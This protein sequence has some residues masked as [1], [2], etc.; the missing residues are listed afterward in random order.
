MSPESVGIVD[1][2]VLAAG[3]STRM[4]F[5]KAVSRRV[6]MAPLERIAQALGKRP[7][8]LVVPARLRALAAKMMPRAAIVTNDEPQRGMT[9]SLR[10][11]LSAVD[12]GS[13]FGVLLGD[14]PAMTEATLARTEALL[15]GNVDVAFPVDGAG[16]PGH[17]V[18][19]SPRARR[20][21]ES[22][23]DGDTLRHARNDA[24]LVRATWICTDASA[25]LDLD[26][27][28]QWETFHA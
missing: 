3:E 10:T 1:Y 4:G 16:M 2:V 20:V 17:P 11:G 13:R 9:H 15:T 22:L 23:Q 7:T 8:V 5:D 28:A 18:L 6:D 25:F 19:F 21:I 26:V 24:S 14:M 12:R 27:P